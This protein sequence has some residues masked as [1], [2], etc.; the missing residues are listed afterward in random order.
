MALQVQ[1]RVGGWQRLQVVGGGGEGGDG[2]P[3]VDA[4]CEGRQ[5]QS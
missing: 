5:A 3:Q 4:L 2:H 1:A